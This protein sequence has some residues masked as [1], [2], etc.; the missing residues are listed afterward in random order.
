MRE[1]AMKRILLTGAAGFVGSH[2]LRHILATTDWF[3]VCPVTFKH[4]GIQDRIRLSIAGNDNY[5]SRI[6][7]INCDLAF[8]ISSI[9]AQEFGSIDYVLNVASESHVD[10]SIE[11]PKGIG[12]D[13]LSRKRSYTSQLMRYMDQLLKVTR[14]ANG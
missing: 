14:T 11:H 4:K 1:F 13:S 12:Q 9:T 2:V 6:K 7:V 10:R 3:V 5:S 8:P